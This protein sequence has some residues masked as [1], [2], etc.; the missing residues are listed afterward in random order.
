MSKHT[1]GPW[2]ADR[3]G[4]VETCGDD[5]ALICECYQDPHWQP[6]GVHAHSNAKLIAAAP[7]LLEACKAARDA[8]TIKLGTYSESEKAQNKIVWQLKAAIAKATG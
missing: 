5:P 8:A 7:E 2:K 6:D 1:P 4:N 3:A